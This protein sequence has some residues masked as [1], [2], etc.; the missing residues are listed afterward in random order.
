MMPEESIR[1][2]SILVRMVQ[3]AMTWGTG[4]LSRTGHEVSYQSGWFGGT[5]GILPI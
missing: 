3:W 4:W 2:G 1:K 5:R